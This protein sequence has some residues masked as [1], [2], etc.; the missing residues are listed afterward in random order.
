MHSTA[1]EPASLPCRVHRHRL[2]LACADGQEI[3]APGLRVSNRWPAGSLTAQPAWGRCWPPLRGLEKEISREIRK[4][5]VDEP[6]RV[7]S[8]SSDTSTAAAGRCTY[9]TTLP[10]IK[11]FLT[12]LCPLSVRLDPF[13]KKRLPYQVRVLDLLHDRDVIELDIEVLVDALEGAADLNI[14]LEL[15]GDR[16]VDQG[17]EEAGEQVSH[18]PAALC[19]IVRNRCSPEEQHPE[20]GP[21]DLRAEIDWLVRSASG[22]CRP[23]PRQS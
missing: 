11:T 7:A 3:A 1:A 6:L 16:G 5:K 9:R 20:R 23:G 18:V 15:D 19:S 10:R 12:A 13:P 8:S 22:L 4:K 2:V 17:L 21:E 14:V